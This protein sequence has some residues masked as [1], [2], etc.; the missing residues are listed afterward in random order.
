[1]EV[2]AMTIEYAEI[3]KQYAEGKQFLEVIAVY[4][5]NGALIPESFIWDDQKV[6]ISRIL[7]SVPMAELNGGVGRRY[8]CL[9]QG[10]QFHLFFDGIRWYMETKKQEIAQALPL[11][12][13]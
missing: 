5:K 4:H 9:A 11:K 8:T 10:K 2:I 3:S 12:K 6:T 1:M 13:A 7:N